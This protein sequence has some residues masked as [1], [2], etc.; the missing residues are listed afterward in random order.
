[1]NGH[2]RSYSYHLFPKFLVIPGYCLMIVAVVLALL[3]VFPLKGWGLVCNFAASPA[4]FIIGLIMVSFRSKLTVDISSGY[5]T[6]ETGLLNMSLS[7][8]KIKI[9]DNCK[10]MIIRSKA[11]T[12][13]GYY[14]YV[15]PV[16][17]NFTSFDMFFYSPSGLKRLINTDKNRA[18]KIAEFIGSALNIECVIEQMDDHGTEGNKTG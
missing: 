3:N 13:T 2:L 16:S 10:K 17:Y 5:V 4:F 1:M 8:E 7:R 11:K 14:R 9:P 15:L 6:K 12:G 18:L